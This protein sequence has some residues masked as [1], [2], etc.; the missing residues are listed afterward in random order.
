MENATL[1]LMI[2]AAAPLRSFPHVRTRWPIPRCLSNY[3]SFSKS[4]PKLKFVSS[5]IRLGEQAAFRA[6]LMAQRLSGKVQTSAIE[7]HNLTLRELMARCPAAPGRWLMTSC[8]C[9]CKPFGHTLWGVTY[10]H[11]ILWGKRFSRSLRCDMT[12]HSLFA[13][14]KAPSPSINI[15]RMPALRAPTTS[16]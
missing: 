4:V 7:R 8:T 12:R 5:I 1:V 16:A 2:R 9:G 3:P 13:S 15:A 6:R 10:Y 11:F 14:G